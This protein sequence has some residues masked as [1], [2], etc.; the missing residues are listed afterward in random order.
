MESVNLVIDDVACS[1]DAFD[2][3]TDILGDAQSKQF[4][5]IYN[6]TPSQNDIIVTNGEKKT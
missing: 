5:T 3:V 6:P 1:H 2:E 4:S